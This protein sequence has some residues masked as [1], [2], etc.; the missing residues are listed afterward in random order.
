[1][2]KKKN[3][4]WLDPLELAFAVS[5]DQNYQKS[6][7]FLYSGLYK[8]N[9]DSFSYLALYPKKQIIAENFDQFS[10]SLKNNDSG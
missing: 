9:P 4:N 2:L 6:W 8:E 1:M 3:L 5:K 7:A 10:E